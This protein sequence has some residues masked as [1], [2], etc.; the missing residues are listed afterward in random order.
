MQHLMPTVI[1]STIAFTFITVKELYINQ[2][3]ENLHYKHNYKKFDSF[4]RI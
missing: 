3:K 1:N 4:T 2:K